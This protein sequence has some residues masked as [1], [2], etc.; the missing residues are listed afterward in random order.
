M[1]KWTALVALLSIAC[2]VAISHAT[3]AVSFL[4]N[5]V[6]AFFEMT[7]IESQYLRYPHSE[8][9]ILNA[10]FSRAISARIRTRD[11]SDIYIVLGNDDS[12]AGLSSKVC[13]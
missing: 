1:E 6:S 13:V 11:Q 12:T 8:A 5:S 4:I 7:Y 3:P 2:F 10:N 9:T